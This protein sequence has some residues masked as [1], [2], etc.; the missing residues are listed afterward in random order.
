MLVVFLVTSAGLAKLPEAGFLKDIAGGD[1]SLSTKQKEQ[2]AQ[3]IPALVQVM[4]TS[5]DA[6]EIVEARN[7]L[8]QSFRISE[9]VAYQETEIN[10]AWAAAQKAFPD[11]KGDLKSVRE[12]NLAVALSS[13]SRPAVR[14]ALDYMIV[15]KN[16]AV[17]Y[18]G[19]TGYRAIRDQLLSF[20]DFADKMR[21]AV[22]ARSAAEPS[23]PVLGMIFE[24][25]LLPPARP[26]GAEATYQAFQDSAFKIVSG[27]WDTRCRQLLGG[28]A[29]LA[30]AMIKGLA[31]VENFNLVFEGNAERKAALL[32][33]AA[34][35][36]VASSLAY[37]KAFAA[38]QSAQQ[39]GEDST[40]FALA[41]EANG[42]LLRECE[43]ALASL[44]GQQ[45][46]LLA[47]A[48]GKGAAAGKVGMAAV[49]WVA[50]LA[51]LG[52]KDPSG[53]FSAPVPASAPAKASAN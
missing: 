27:C 16:P 34:D 24:T 33:M 35:V 46:N 15:H 19:W 43:R 37:E 41:R 29:Q 18:C 39:T 49:D 20:K 45:R 28:D 11:L 13:M 36:L 25:C 47:Q 40:V 17:R 31:A 6:K 30:E 14:P 48:L 42:Q 4:A 51:P 50:A 10:L 52:V 7:A 2:L 8:T 38:Q 23:G 12:I 1:G 44:S 22:E 21:A 26:A 3:Y 9:N 5:G 53:R 32:Q